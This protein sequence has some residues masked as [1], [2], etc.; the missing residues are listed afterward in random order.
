MSSV[1]TSYGVSEIVNIA[2]LLV[3]EGPVIAP[4]FGGLADGMSLVDPVPF[5]RVNAM[6]AWQL[7]EI[8]RQSRKVRRVVTVGSRAAYGEYAPEEGP[9]NEEFA[10]R[11]TGIYGASKAAADLVARVYRERLGVD[12]VVARVTGVYG[13]WQ[14]HAQP[15]SRMVDAAVAGTPFSLAAGGDYMYEFTYVKDVVRALLL[16]LDAPMLRHC[17]YNVGVGVQHP[18]SAVARTI[19]S[20]VP[21]ATIDVGPGVPLGV[22]LRAAL[23]VDRIASDVGF[24]AKWSLLEGIAE[25]IDWR[26]KGTYGLAV[27]ASRSPEPTLPS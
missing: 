23:S 27:E 9:I 19:R 15:L 6:A 11:P 8:A 1:V 16:L 2:S 7:C 26:R 20:I 21:E 22:P 5:L 4:Q 18:L 12:V 25:F 17:I 3:V 10:L 14:T 13:P 24:R